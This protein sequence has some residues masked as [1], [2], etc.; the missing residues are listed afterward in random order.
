MAAAAVASEASRHERTGVSCRR[1]RLA[2]AASRWRIDA[3]ETAADR[4]LPGL[5]GAGLIARPELS[6]EL[7]DELLGGAQT[8]QEIAGPDGLLGQLDAPADAR[9]LESRA[10]MPRVRGDLPGELTFCNPR[11]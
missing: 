9:D 6:D 10:V 1:T 2:G 8:A 3:R 4:A 5:P 7:I 11:S